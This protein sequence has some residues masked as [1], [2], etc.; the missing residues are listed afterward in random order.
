MTIV[1]ATLN[2]DENASHAFIIQSAMPTAI[3]II[4]LSEY[5][6]YEKKDVAA[7]VVGTSLLSLISLPTINSILS[8]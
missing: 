7:M 6:N 5:F 1:C 4:L 3:S 2:I 8:K